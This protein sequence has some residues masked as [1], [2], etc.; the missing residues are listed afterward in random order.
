[1]ALSYI[2]V[3]NETD[4]FKWAIIEHLA[5]YLAFPVDLVPRHH[6][7]GHL[8]GISLRIYV[9]CL[10]LC[11]PRVSDG[12]VFINHIPSNLGKV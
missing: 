2:F 4:L 11:R 9:F 3:N 8:F 1:M 12:H 6:V 5:Q 10:S 7:S